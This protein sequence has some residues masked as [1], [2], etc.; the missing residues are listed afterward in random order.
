MKENKARKGK[1][2]RRMRMRLRRFWKEREKQT[3]ER[4][5][6]KARKSD[7]SDSEK[8]GRKN[9]NRVKREYRK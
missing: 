6:S 2:K 7:R 3:L 4:M 9:F 8:S 5:N 1:T